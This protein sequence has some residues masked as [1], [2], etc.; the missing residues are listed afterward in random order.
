MA[1][2][3]ERKLSKAAWAIRV[4]PRHGEPYLKEAMY[5]TIPDLWETRAQARTFIH[6]NKCSSRDRWTPVRVDV[7]ER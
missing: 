3:T 1:K 7:I 6:N 4:D 5:D 2:K